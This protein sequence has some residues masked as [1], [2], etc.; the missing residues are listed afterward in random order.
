MINLKSH[1]PGAKITIMNT[2]AGRY[3]DND[4][5]YHEG[6]ILVYKDPDT[7]IKYAHEITDPPYTFYVANDDSRV[8][9]NRLFVEEKD[10]HPV[11]VPHKQVEREIAKITG[12]LSFFKENIDSQNFRQNRMLHTH[13]DIFQSDMDIEDYYRMQFDREYV[14]EPCK[15]IKSYFDIEADTISMI[16]DF[17]QM[18]ECPINAVTLILQEQGEVF[19]F[20]LENPRNPQIA[21]F[22]KQVEDKSIYGELQ[23]FII[24]A[25]NGPEAA[26]HFGVDS[27][28]F[29][30]LFYKEEDE[31]NLIKD[32]FAAI[33]SYKPDFILAWNMSFDVPYII[34]RIINLGY[35]P[36]DIICN[37]DFNI[38][39]C[40]YYV[41]ERNK[42]ELAE[43][44]D[45]AS[46]S[47][48]TCFVD[49]MIQYASRRKGQ[50]RPLSFSLDYIGELVAKVRKLD[51]KHITTN[52][53][54]LPYKDYKTFVFYNI[55][56]VIVQVCIESRT[57]DLDFMFSK[58][59][60]NNTR[61]A[62]VHRQTVYLTNRGVKEF[63]KDGFIFGNNTNKFNPKPENK[64]PGAFV[65][66][67]DRIKDTSKI[68]IGGIPISVFNY[69]VDFDKRIV[70]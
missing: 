39:Y 23:D 21:E 38:R 54:E 61:Y 7:G 66:Q 10:V 20:L 4:G 30:F 6:L 41:D 52:I 33:N 1:K 42:N 2:L 69:L 44:G 70:A 53:S 19:T 25:V 46:I 17:P 13:P 15:I 24:K 34:Q 37:P 58:A 26:K 50:A 31:I 36:S 14:N 8:S 45:F 5:K 22:K 35:D 64:F 12:N 18:G 9:Y 60:V 47:S 62:K 29:N 16:G 57:G 3:K 67:M 32:L 43:R 40:S 65:A 68:R 63:H 51:Y 56:D 59:L 55:M 48:Y 27:F 49:Q 28:N 11:T